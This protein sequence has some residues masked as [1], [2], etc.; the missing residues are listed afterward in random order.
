[1]VVAHISPYRNGSRV[2][3]LLVVVTFFVLL[4]IT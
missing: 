3:A 2:F 4:L 1:V